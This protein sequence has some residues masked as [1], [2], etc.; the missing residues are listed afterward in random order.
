MAAAAAPLPAAATPKLASLKARMALPPTRAARLGDEGG[1]EGNNGG[2]GGGGGGLLALLK[3][4][5]MIGAGSTSHS[6]EP[7]GTALSTV[8]HPPSTPYVSSSLHGPGAAATA[9]P[10]MA[11][12]SSFEDLVAALEVSRLTTEMDESKRATFQQDCERLRRRVRK[13]RRGLINP[14]SK[15]VQY[16]DL[17]TTLALL[18]TA[19]VTPFEVCLGLETKLNILFGINLVV[20]L[21]FACDIVAQFFLPFRDKAGEL[22]RSHSRIAHNYL[23]SWFVLDVFTVLPFD[24]ATVA[25]PHLFEVECG[26]SGSS[27][28]L[29]GFK[30]LRVL[31]L[32][33]LMRM[34]RGM[35]ILQRWEASISITTSLRSLITAI[36]LFCVLLHW[37]GCLWAL[38]PQ[39]QSPPRDYPGLAEAMANRMAND[40]TCEAC[41]C[42]DDPLLVPA[43]INPC[44]TP[45]EA[46]ELAMLMGTNLN[47]VYNNEYWTCRAVK[48]GYLMPDFEKRPASTWVVSLLVA[49]LQLLGGFGTITP[50]NDAES[51]VSIFSI[52]VGTVVY[53]G[54]Q[55]LLIRVLT[56]G[57]PDE[58]VFRQSLDAL[59]YMMRDQHL[60][61]EVRIRVR[62]YFRRAKDFQKR[63]SYVELIDST[64]SRKL[65]GELHYLISRRVFDSVWWLVQCEPDFLKALA[66][67]T[68]RESYAADEK[69]PNVRARAR[70]A[71]A[72]DT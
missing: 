49:M 21:I 31:R 67:C 28:L 30:L 61:N 66:S 22:V 44:L 36:T 1:G 17:T 33:K 58:M 26:G 45:C 14:R 15:K 54:V 42:G 69:I 47:T 6:P 55:G 24:I 12:I 13:T 34:L 65:Q 70:A 51:I 35:R 41:L 50:A 60:P 38:L 39:L 53:A 18:F 2:G 7:P 3:A 19:S 64:L 71:R 56:T 23:F 27:T 20:N 57:N 59:N 46:D 62:D 29:K 8:V 16:W 40:P 72:G 68:E 32:V 48:S 52:L 37:L 5:G 63:K 43:C 9:L 4:K 10:V 11:S 25:A